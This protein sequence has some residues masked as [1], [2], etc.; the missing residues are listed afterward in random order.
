MYENAFR[1][2]KEN[3]TKALFT[4]QDTYEAYGKM[5]HLAFV[6]VF[7]ACTFGGWLILLSIMKKPKYHGF[8]YFNEG[9]NPLTEDILKQALKKT[10]INLSEEEN[11]EILI[12]PKADQFVLFTSKR[13]YYRMLQDAKMTTTQ[14]TQGVIDL[15]AVKQ[16]K[17]N[18]HL[19]ETLS[20]KVNDDVIGTLDRANFGKMK[21]LFKELSK[22]I[23]SSAG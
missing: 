12:F 23:I 10:D 20:I 5:Y 11:P 1:L 22:D 21:N 2:A 14:K 15:G 18:G 7:T 13:I 4:G 8:I 3:E 19:S 16:L 17:T 6:L 9:P